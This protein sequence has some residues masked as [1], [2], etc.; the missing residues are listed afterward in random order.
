MRIIIFGQTILSQAILKKL[1]ELEADII[2][3]VTI[4]CCNMKSDNIDLT[5]ACE[6]NGIDIFYT[7]EVNSTISEQ[8]IKDRKPDIIFCVGFRQIIK[9]NILDI[10]KHGIIGHHPEQLPKNRGCSPII[11]PLVLGLNQTASTFFKMN[12]GIDSGEIIDQRTIKI[13]SCDN[14]WNLYEKVI[15]IS[16]IQIKDIIEGKKLN[17]PKVKQESNYWRKR[18]PEKDG[19]V[20]FRMCATAIYNLVRALSYPYPGAKV[21]YKGLN[22]K[23]NKVEIYSNSYNVYQNIESGKIIELFDNEIIVK[24]YDGAI[25]II[26]H[27]FEALPKKGEYL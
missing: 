19:I 6:D 26:D 9:K 13:S 5:E 10:P 2:G 7:N 18:I 21:N 23:I 27:E 24:C 17:I 20:D 25:K 1:I 14:A 8:W 15:N 3:V 4:E 12:E 16:C 11:W 22:V